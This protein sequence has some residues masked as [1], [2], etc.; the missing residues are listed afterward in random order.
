MVEGPDGA[1]MLGAFV[2]CVQVASRCQP[3]GTLLRKGGEPHDFASIASRTR[4]SSEIVEK[5]LQKAILPQ[6]KWIEVVEIDADIEIPQAARRQPA[7]AAHPTD[8]GKKEGMEGKKEGINNAR[9]SGRA[10]R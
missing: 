3:R 1:A 6:I 10:G 2:A 5:M 7:G 4:L 9:A 8:Y